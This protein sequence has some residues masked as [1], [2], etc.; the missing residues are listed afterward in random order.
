MK[1][2]PEA[3]DYPL[4]KKVLEAD[5]FGALAR[6]TDEVFRQ[7]VDDD[8]RGRNDPVIRAAL[9]SSENVDRWFSVL[10]SI[11]KSVEGQLAARKADWETKRTRLLTD[12]QLL[13]GTDDRVATNELKVQL[14]EEREKYTR[15]R[16]GIIRFK[17]G[18]DV[19]LAE[20]R[21]LRDASRDGMYQRVTEDERIKLATRVHALED[22][23]RHHRDIILSDVSDDDHE[24]ADE[25]LWGLIS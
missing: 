14:Q 4:L 24:D 23:I 21:H 19:W 16:A 8:L 5:G 12:I 6:S 20:A 18:L 7:L 10:L 9:R 15:W 13:E 1:T 17:T 11:S 22:G 3:V 2:M 25:D